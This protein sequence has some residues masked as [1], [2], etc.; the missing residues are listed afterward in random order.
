M[1][2]KTGLR[3]LFAGGLV[4]LSAEIVRAIEADD[5]GEGYIDVAGRRT[6]RPASRAMD[7]LR[8]SSSAPEVA[9]E[10]EADPRAQLP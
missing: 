4:P 6:T 2:R 5:E 3:L 8:G 1:A 9:S 7:S 10:T